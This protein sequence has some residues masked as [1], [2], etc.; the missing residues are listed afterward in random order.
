[1]SDGLLMEP[2]IIH[3]CTKLPHDLP[4]ISECQVMHYLF[5]KPH[6]VG[7]EVKLAYLILLVASAWVISSHEPTRPGGEGHITFLYLNS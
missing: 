6:L 4:L 3:P 2:H 7:L 1:M 5:K